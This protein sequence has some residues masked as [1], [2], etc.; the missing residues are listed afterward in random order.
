MLSNGNNSMAFNN[1]AEMPQLPYKVVTTLLTEE[2]QAAEDFWKLLKYTDVDALKKNNLTYEEKMNLIWMGDSIEQNYNVFLKPLIG[3]SLDTAEA[4]TQLR[5]F[6]YTTMPSTR[7]EAVMTIEIDFITNEKTCLVYQ[8]GILCERTDLMEA[9]FLDIMN[10]RDI[11]IGSG[12]V[13]FDRELSRSC[14][15]Q[16][17][18]GNSKSFYGRSLV[19]ALEFISGESGGLCG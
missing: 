18:I 9:L 13:M 19:M 5:I 15:S 1:Y 14:N 11:E 3:S 17:N 6:R 2:S 7:F 8:N 16:L 4:Q 10:G 12:V